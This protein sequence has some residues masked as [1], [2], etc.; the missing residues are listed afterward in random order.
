M[1]G[2]WKRFNRFDEIAHAVTSIDEPH[3]MV[4]EGFMYEA[5]AYVTAVTN[6]ANYDILLAVPA[7]TFPHF[8][9]VR[10]H[11]GDTPGRVRMYEGVTTSDDGSAVTEFNRNRNSANTPG[12]VVTTAP[13]VSDTG[14]L[15]SD[16]LVPDV[17]GFLAAGGFEE[18]GFGE[19]WIL[20]PSTKYLVRFTNSSGGSIAISWKLR[21][22]EVDY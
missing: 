18:A 3:N 8:R 13:T 17:G 4:H 20:Q 7:A 2:Y 14:T 6:A 9:E 11:L 22:Y 5:G 15:L 16:K 21:W 12:T 1:T 10:L 19:E